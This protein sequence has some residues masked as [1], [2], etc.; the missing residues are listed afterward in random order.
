MG[1]Y[2]ERHLY[3]NELI[4]EKAFRDPWN[5]VGWWI[6][7]VLCCWMLFIPTIIAIIKTIKYNCT[8]LVLTDKRVIRKEGVFHTRSIDV[9]LDKVFNVFVRTTFWGKVFNTNRIYI[10]TEDGFIVDKIGHA[11]QFKSTILGQVDYFHEQRLARQASWTAQAMARSQ[12][13]PNGYYVQPGQMYYGMPMN[14]NPN[15]R[16]RRDDD[17]YDDYGFD[18]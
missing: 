6:F 17:A 4:V 16:P 2:V 15:M 8:E 12:Q 10:K 14:E 5:L 13:P 9:P 11:D 7:G 3:E 18:I 1:R